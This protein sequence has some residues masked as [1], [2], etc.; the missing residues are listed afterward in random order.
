LVITS[1]LWRA[2]ETASVFAEATGVPLRTDERL[3]E[4]NLGQWQGLTPEE[5]EKG[6][7][8]RFSQWRADPRFAPP[9]GESRI[10]VADR[11]VSLLRELWPV[12]FGPAEFGSED[13][14]TSAEEST[15]MLATHSGLISSLT[16][17]LLRLPPETWQSLRGP[18][19]CHWVELVW[20]ERQW[21]LHAY[22]AGVVS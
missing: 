1:D 18:N 5:V 7:P 20:R 16:G 12:E 9:G 13:K 6:W 4:T 19:N 17:R 10:Q 8:G 15:I 3:R 11:A 22:N 21:R 2:A 14:G